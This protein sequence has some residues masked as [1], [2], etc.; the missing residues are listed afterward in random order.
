MSRHG[1]DPTASQGIA[2]ANHDRPRHRSGCKINGGV[3]RHG[4]NG[5]HCAACA[6]D[7][8]EERLLDRLDRFVG[9]GVHG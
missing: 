8:R 9:G 7:D 5:W 3:R 6:P 4:V 2:R 1:F